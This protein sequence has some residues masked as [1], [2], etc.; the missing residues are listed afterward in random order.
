MEHHVQIVATIGPATNT[1]EKIAALSAAG[2][3]IARLNFS[4]GTHAEHAGYIAAIREVAGDTGKKILIMQDLSGPR[5]NTGD[6]HG[7]DQTAIQ[8]ITEKDRADLSFGIAHGV[9]I[10]AQSFVAGPDDVRQ[11]KQLIR[12]LGGNARV[13]AKIER[14]EAL[15]EIDQIIMEADAIMIARGDLG[16]AISAATLPKVEADIIGRCN[17]SGTPVIVATELLTSMLREL[18]PTRAEVTDVYFAVTHGTDA[19]MLSD[20]TAVGAHPTEAVAALRSIAD[21]VAHES[22]MVLIRHAIT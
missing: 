2:M 19:L 5:T 21:Q 11:L 20:E 7:L 12:G 13:V 9:D 18:R 14:A 3:D 8:S 22:D 15:S 4:W 17:R 16:E 6:G 1:K 10:V